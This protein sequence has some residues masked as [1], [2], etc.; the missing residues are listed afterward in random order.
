MLYSLIGCTA[1]NAEPLPE[2]TNE[3]KGMFEGETGEQH[4]NDALLIDSR[5]QVDGE[6]ERI[7]TT[8]AEAL[9]RERL[10]ID[11]KS[12]TIVVYDRELE[13]GL[14]VIHVYD[15][16]NNGQNSRRNTSDKWYTVNS[17]TKEIKKYNK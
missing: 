3:P 10:E 4:S 16:V 12:D 14:Y 6:N 2:A 11:P 9:V 7:S 5:S 8:D 13:N 17:K 15:V 1:N